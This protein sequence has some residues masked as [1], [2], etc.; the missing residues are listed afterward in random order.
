[1]VAGTI[2]QR[3]FQSSDSV[4]HTDLEPGQRKKD[5]LITLWLGQLQPIMVKKYDIWEDLF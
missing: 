2:L 5:S 3:G 4:G 1:M